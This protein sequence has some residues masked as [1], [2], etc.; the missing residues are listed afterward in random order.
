MYTLLKIIIQKCI[1]KSNC[2]IEKCDTEM[3]E[4]ENKCNT[5][6]NLHEKCECKNHLKRYFKGKLSMS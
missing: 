1:W 4:I 3:P 6:K 5:E 2:Q